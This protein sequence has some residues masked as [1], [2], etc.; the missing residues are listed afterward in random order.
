MPSSWELEDGARKVFVGTLFVVA[1]NASDISS[2]NQHWVKSSLNQ[3]AISK[4][5]D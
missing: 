1:V 3:V 5:H 2:A 4:D